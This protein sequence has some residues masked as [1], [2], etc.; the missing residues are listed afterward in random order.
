MSICVEEVAR[1]GCRCGDGGAIGQACVELGGA[2][3]DP[4]EVDVAVDDHRH[5]H[6]VDV[7]ARP[8]FRRQHRTGVCDDADH[9]MGFRL[10]RNLVRI[11]AEPNSANAM[12]L[13]P[14]GGPHA[15]GR[16]RRHQSRLA[17]TQAAQDKPVACSASRSRVA[18][19]NATTASIGKNAGKTMRQAPAEVATPLPPRPCFQI[20]TMWPGRRCLVRARRRW[21][22]CSCR[23][24]APRGPT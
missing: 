11:I 24:R 6:D 1:C 15:L 13:G 20:G 17:T 5:R 14:A 23:R 19:R 18:P 22:L 3:V 12:V 8:E 2:E 7:E 16:C 9:L 4:F 10:S 21:R